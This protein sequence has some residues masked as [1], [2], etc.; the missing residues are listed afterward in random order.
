[1]KR[2]AIIDNLEKKVKAQGPINAWSADQIMGFANEI[3]TK[4]MLCSAI[5]PDD[6][7]LLRGYVRS[8][9]TPTVAMKFNAV[10]KTSCVEKTRD[11]V[12]GCFQLDLEEKYPQA[13]GKN[14]TKVNYVN[15]LDKLK[16]VESRKN[17]F[18]HTLKLAIE[19]ATTPEI[20]EL[21]KGNQYA[22]KLERYVRTY[23][24]A[25]ETVGIERANNRLHD[26]KEGSASVMYFFGKVLREHYLPVI[27]QKEREMR[28]K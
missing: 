16:V 26:L 1:M 8:Y 24:A 13:D 28:S 2:D 14:E 11:Y 15:V 5:H 23:Q 4:K 12:I 21:M 3:V 7:D 6:V 19:V 10:L 22:R 25:V 20:S 27:R 18:S 17:D 9:Y